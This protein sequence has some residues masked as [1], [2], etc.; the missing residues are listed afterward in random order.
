MRPL[1]TRLFGVDVGTC[2]THRFQNGYQ[3]IMVGVEHPMADRDGYAFLHHMV[4]KSA[5]FDID[6]SKTVGH[7]NGNK[8]DNRIS[9]LIVVD[10]K[11]KPAHLSA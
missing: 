11:P 9:N 5:G 1:Q 10:R 6:P 4:Y 3:K 7:S 2:R 8:K